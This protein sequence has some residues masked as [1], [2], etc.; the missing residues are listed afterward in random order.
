MKL[1]FKKTYY[2]HLIENKIRYK[3]INDTINRLNIENIDIYYTTAVNPLQ[4]IIGDILEN[5]RI[6][7]FWN[8]CNQGNCL[9]NFVSIY[10]LIKIAYYKN[11]DSI[12]IFEDDI[13]FDLDKKDLIIDTLNNIPDDWECLRIH[14]TAGS[15]I[16]NEIND[17]N[18]S[19]EN[20]TVNHNWCLYN[21]YYKGINGTNCFALKRNAMFGYIKMCENICHPIQ[22]LTKET[23]LKNI[24]DYKYKLPHPV[25]GDNILNE[26]T[27][28]FKT[29]VCYKLITKEI[30]NNKSTVKK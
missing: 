25:N 11:Y 24:V 15:N 22:S 16:T 6:M 18:L 2:L 20:P 12:C 13:I 14:T 7:E 10:K 19:Y 30:E 23:K 27:K 5:T 17:N 1:P 4:N 9:S 28:F 8:D 3:Y 26:L 29:Y 21:K